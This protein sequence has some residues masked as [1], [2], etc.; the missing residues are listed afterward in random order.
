MPKSRRQNVPGLARN[1]HYVPR[2][3][4]RQ[5][6]C[7]PGLLWVAKRVRGKWHIKARPISDSFRRDGLYDSYPPIPDPSPTDVV[8]RHLSG[9]ESRVA[10]VWHRL[11]R[12][13]ERRTVLLPAETEGLLKRHM[14]LQLTRTPR[15]FERVRADIR[16]GRP[17]IDRA[18]A[19]VEAAGGRVTEADRRAIEDGSMRKDC[20]QTAQARSVVIQDVRSP[21]WRILMEHRRLVVGRAVNNVRFVISD[22][23]VLYC[24]S[25]PGT[26]ST[27][28]NPHLQVWT[29]LS[30]RYALGLVDPSGHLRPGAVVSVNSDR[31]LEWNESLFRDCSVCAGRISS[32]LSILVSRCE[33]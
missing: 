11:C 20:L 5:W 7:K 32:D 21:S 33:N 31:V 19:R 6:S 15:F 13:L 3:V 26:G 30:P 4:L 2:W 22:H 29:P 8:E 18:V 28:A 25:V 24:N 1:H 16:Y 27:L 10:A 14:W 9:I 12:T 23:P 17:E